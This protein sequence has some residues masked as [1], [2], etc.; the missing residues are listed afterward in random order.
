MPTYE[1]QVGGSLKLDSPTYVERQ[2][3]FD[4]HE[5]LLAGELCYV[6]NSRQMGKSS[7]RVQ[8]RSQLQQ[9]GMR[10]A[11]L[12]M[13]RIGSE[14]VTPQQWYKGIAMDL[15]RNFDLLGSFDFKQ[16]WKQREDLPILQ[17]L[18]LLIEDVLLVKFPEERLFIFVDEIDSALSLSFPTDDFFT[19]IRY[20][21]NQR[22]ENPIYDRLTWALFGV[23]TPSDLIRDRTRTPFNI[24]KAIELRGFQ[25]CGAQ[26]LIV[27]LQD[28][29][30]NPQVVLQSILD[31]TGGQPFLTQRLCK[32]V[33][34]LAEE[35][36]SGGAPIQIPPG[37]EP[38]WMERLVRSHII[39]NWESQDQPEH[40][41]TIRDRL[42]RDEQRAGRLLGVYQQIL[43]NHQSKAVSVER[44]IPIE[45]PVPLDRRV[46]FEKDEADTPEQIELLLS[47]L[48]EK[49][50]GALQVK[51][52]I[53]REVFNLDWVDKQL[54]ALRPY[55]EPMNN[56]LHSSGFD[57][58]RLLRGQAL[59]DAQAW[60]QGKRLSNQD[61][62]FLA[63]SQRVDR[64]ET[65]LILEAERAHEVEARL[66]VE[67]KSGKRQRQLLGLVS[68]ALVGAT[69]LGI[70]SYVQFR[71]AAVHEVEAI[72]AFSKGLYS[73]DERLDA[74]VAALTAARR[75]QQFG[76]LPLSTQHEVE[77]ALRR[78]IYGATEYNRFSG[79]N[80]EVLSITLSAYG[81]KAVS[82]YSNGT[83]KIW[84]WDGTLLKTLKAHTAQVF[85]VRFNP[86]GQTFASVSEDGTLKLW[87]IDGTLIHTFTGHKA[88]VWSVAFSPGGGFLASASEDQTVKIWKLDG[89]LVT[90]LKGHSA[91]VWDVAFS[92]GLDRGLIATAGGDDVINLWKW[93]SNGQIESQ[94]YKVL[95]GHK[96][97]VMS[98]AFNPNW[99]D[100]DAASSTFLA[101]GGEDNIMILWDSSG[102]PRKTIRAHDAAINAITFNRDGRLIATASGD[103]T[104]KLWNTDG[105][106]LSTIK[107]HRSAVWDVGFSGNGKFLASASSDSMVKL[108][109]PSEILQQRL[110]GHQSIVW[111][112]SF[113]PDGQTI[114]TASSD[115]S[116]KLWH[117]DGRLIHTLTGYKAA[118]NQ[119][120][121]SPNGQFLATAG[122]DKHIRLWTLEGKPFSDFVGHNAPIM[123]LAISPD[124]Q[125][126]ASGS[127]DRTIRLWKPDGT[128]L[129]TLN[130]HT[131]RVV[132]LAFDPS[133][134]LLASSSGD[135]S[136]KLWQR[137]KTGRF[138]THADQT[139]KGDSTA[140]GI[141]FSPDGQ[142]LASARGDGTIHLW[143]QVQ[144]KF[145]DQPELILKGHRAAVVGI[146][147]SPNGQ[148]LASSSVDG[149]IKLWKR[150]GTLLTTLTGHQAGVWAVKFSPNGQTLASVGDDQTAILWD[151]ERIVRLDL[152]Q[153]G[154]QWVGDYLEHNEEVL[155]GDRHL[156]DQQ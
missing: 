95:K 66:E 50:Q 13:T 20:C 89:T 12:D 125:L 139:L 8:M 94:P 114:A 35:N 22:A 96:T 74:L 18:S 57:E 7:L 152:F 25:P 149:T 120:V 71:Q 121:F 136:I 29:V 80:A 10:C 61:Y 27:G 52:R 70:G 47:G 67:R 145:P 119:V 26:P 143:H 103:N 142:L 23:A 56:W 98:L 126:I 115:P 85:R 46:D 11:T 109:K 69:G 59:Q 32:L 147:F 90:T 117:P 154:C 151:V 144:G 153:Y 104:L 91:P 9:A 100:K 93:R 141:A 134:R 128:L 17:R 73:A 39:H 140:S 108:W 156:C 54:T 38:Y 92:P 123:S 150:D 53:Y 65:Q 138:S 64:R 146:A 127:S 122:D 129:I 48:V 78:T 111:D 135:G 45:R 137:D 97:A 99:S 42:L 21:H 24:G 44:R 132:G 43:H 5:A 4:L 62:Q 31:W 72:A 82:S 107:G 110:Y 51:N 3:D 49:Q 1:Y 113:S 106:P 87:N 124:N 15:L 155:E 105:M 19:L 102:K 75:S 148:V 6:F 76:K 34:I 14:Q 101:S 16:W 112:V 88:P 2:A 63:A 131:A 30:S 68:L 116:V 40:L 84:Q 36:E 60:S 79:S 41:R 33:Q 133:S 86:D 83:I 118:V 81:E 28:R 55:A 58:S 130:G 77:A 37:T